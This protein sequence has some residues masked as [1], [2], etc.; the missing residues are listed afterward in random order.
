[1]PNN[2]FTLSDF[3]DLSSFTKSASV[4][5]KGQ[6]QLKN[7]SGSTSPEGPNLNMTTLGLSEIMQGRGLYRNT[8]SSLAMN[9][10]IV[11]ATL[12]GALKASGEASPEN[13]LG[14]AASLLPADIFL[15]TGTHC[16]GS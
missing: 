10:Q 12:S 4:M 16:Q 3:S 15:L 14:G 1:M 7:T 11:S 2:K 6:V 5:Q 8:E 9:Q 13:V